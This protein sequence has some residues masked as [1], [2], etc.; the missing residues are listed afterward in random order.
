VGEILARGPN[1]MLGYSDDPDATAQVIDADGWLRTGDLGKLDRRGRLSIVGRAKD[2]IV[3]S[4]G[5]NVYPDDL[6][7][8]IGRVEGVKELCILGV[9]D[10]RGGERIACVAVADRESDN[11]PAVQR[12]RAKRE[13][14]EALSKLPSAQKPALVL[15]FDKDL[16]RTTTRKVRRGEVRAE[17]ERRERSQ[18]LA[19]PKGPLDGAASVVRSTIAT[20]A[21]RPVAKIAA[22]Q[23]LRGRC[24]PVASGPGESSA[25]SASIRRAL[26]LIS[27]ATCSSRASRLITVRMARATDSETSLSAFCSSRLGMEPSGRGPTSR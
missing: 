3:A 15:I 2:V 4:N 7:A 8:R 5:E 26:S 21:R 19:Q 9:P 25:S 27:S 24:R 12:A 1:V 14:D 13:L 11:P 10:G 23:A 20:I 22:N 16:P 17:I 18:E 6:E